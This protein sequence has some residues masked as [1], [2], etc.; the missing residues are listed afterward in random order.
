MSSSNSLDPVATALRLPS[1]K[2]NHTRF[3][4]FI[5]RGS[6]PT[7]EQVK[8]VLGQAGAAWTTLVDRVKERFEPVDERWLY[9]GTHYGWSLRLG[10]NKRPILYLCPRENDFLASIAIN[11]SVMKH[12]LT[13]DF[14]YWVES[15]LRNAPKFAEGYAVRFAIHEIDQIY[16]VLRLVELKLGNNNHQVRAGAST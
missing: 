3:S 4:A 12:A 2:M 5:R 9:G 6:P 7:A 11:E 13:S 8:D 16:H 10:R 1:R 14:P 15:V